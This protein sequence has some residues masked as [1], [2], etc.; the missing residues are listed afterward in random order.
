MKDGETIYIII[1]KSGHTCDEGR[2][3]L[4]GI[5]NGFHGPIVTGTWKTIK[6][7]FGI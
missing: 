6:T 2:S 5:G 3:E 1:P 7:Y 4:W